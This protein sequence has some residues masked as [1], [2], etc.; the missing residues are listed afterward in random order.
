MAWP[1]LNS[2]WTHRASIGSW[3]SI[4]ASGDLWLFPSTQALTFPWGYCKLRV[5]SSRFRSRNIKL[6]T[7]LAI[8]EPMLTGS[9]AISEQTHKIH[10][11]IPGRDHFH[12]LNFFVH[13]PA[14]KAGT[15]LTGVIWASQGA[16]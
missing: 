16:L 11:C 13:S 2:K 14:G 5:A 6:I 10:C 12:S 4:H 3:K 8:Y 7:T 9:K 15:I 1:W